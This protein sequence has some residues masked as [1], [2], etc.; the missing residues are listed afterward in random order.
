MLYTRLV[1]GELTLSSTRTFSF[2]HPAIFSTAINS[3]ILVLVIGHYRSHVDTTSE[4]GRHQAERSPGRRPPRNSAGCRAG[5]GSVFNWVIPPRGLGP[6]DE[7]LTSEER[8][9]LEDEV[10][11]ARV[12]PDAGAS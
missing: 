2:V 11:E 1:R 10:L 12:W 5:Y 3:F 6:A 7:E 8:K 4:Q 9:A